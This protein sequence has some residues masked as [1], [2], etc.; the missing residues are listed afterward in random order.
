MINVL[1]P[2]F[3]LSRMQFC[4]KSILW[5]YGIPNDFNNLLVRWEI[6]AKSL[7]VCKNSKW[8]WYHLKLKS[9][10]S[11]SESRLGWHYLKLKSYQMK[12]NLR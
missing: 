12:K 3:T 9:C 5:N 7:Y 10:T 11:Y 2:Q 1:Q 8:G 6:L 4:I